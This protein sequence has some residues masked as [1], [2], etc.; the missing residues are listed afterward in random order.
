MQAYGSCNQS[1]TV[2]RELPRLGKVWQGCSTLSFFG[3]PYQL[4]KAQSKTPFEKI[5][6][7]LAEPIFLRSFKKVI[8][9]YGVGVAR[10][11]RIKIGL[12][13]KT[14]GNL[15][16]NLGRTFRYSHIVLS[17]T[18]L[19]KVKEKTPGKR[20]SK[21]LGSASI[22]AAAIDNVLQQLQTWPI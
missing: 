6:V 22:V 19:F 4:R 9:C 17:L 3:C 11:C 1:L 12:R 5:S 15:G 7:L 13:L 21:V 20:L 2:R 10:G 8:S 16:G 14:V 18:L